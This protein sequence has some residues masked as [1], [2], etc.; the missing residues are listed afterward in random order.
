MT[1]LAPDSPLPE[2]AVT[3]HQLLAEANSMIVAATLEDALLVEERPNMPGTTDQWP[4]WRI[5]LPVSIDELQ[6]RPL[7]RQIAEVLSKR[8]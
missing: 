5:A 4:N 3:M 1:G 8:A 7:P 2:V 6:S